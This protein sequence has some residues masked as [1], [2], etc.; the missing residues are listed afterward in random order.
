MPPISGHPISQETKRGFKRRREAGVELEDASPPGDGSGSWRKERETAVS[1]SSVPRLSRAPELSESSPL[2]VGQ[3]AALYAS[4][5]PPP[6][7]L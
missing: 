7:E 4:G 5:S 2:G 3:I 1:V 6:F